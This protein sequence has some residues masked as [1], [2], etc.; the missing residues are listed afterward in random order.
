M[1]FCNPVELFLSRISQL[2]LNIADEFIDT[3]TNF[4]CRLAKHRGGD[5]LEIRDLQLHL[6]EPFNITA[7]DGLTTIHQ[8]EIITSEYQVLHQMRHGYRCLRQRWHLLYQQQQTKRTHRV[9]IRVWELSVS[10]RFN[11]QSGKPS[12]C[13]D[14]HWTHRSSLPYLLKQP[15][16]CLLVLRFSCHFMFYHYRHMYTTIL[17]ATRYTISCS[18]HCLWEWLSHGVCPNLSNLFLH[19]HLEIRKEE[20]PS[21]FSLSRL[22]PSAGWDH[23]AWVGTRQWGKLQEIDA[24]KRLP[25][26]PGHKGLPNHSSLWL[27]D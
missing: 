10:P 23:S 21:E 8:N 17:P 26:E 25:C 20:G 22:G 6:G 4:S 13:N 24:H 14:W 3:V 7:I 5:S 15:C 11:R 1:S 16:I 9:R 19:R 18:R 2:L 12:W 27:I